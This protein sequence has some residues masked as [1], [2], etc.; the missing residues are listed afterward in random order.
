[1]QLKLF[2]L[3]S[4]MNFLRGGF[5]S[6]VS[7]DDIVV[8]GVMALVLLLAL[9]ILWDAVLFLA[10]VIREREVAESEIIVVSPL[11]GEELDEAI[12]L[13]DKRQEEFDEILAR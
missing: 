11:R 8:W 4:I 6:R 10:T 2:Q 12:R 3:T 13:L 5:K 9:V 7:R 1:M